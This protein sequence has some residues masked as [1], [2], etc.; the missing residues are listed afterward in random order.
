MRRSDLA[1]FLLVAATALALSPTPRAQDEPPLFDEKA[2]PQPSPT[3]APEA[4]PSPAPE[5]PKAA[6]EAAARP[7]VI[8]SPLSAR[9]D[10]ARWQSMTPR[11]RQVFVEGA[12]TALAT[13]TARLRTEVGGDSRAN[14]DKMV[15]LVRFIH[16]NEPRHTAD[17]YLREMGSLYL[18]P[19]GQ[20]LSIPECFARALARLNGR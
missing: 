7:A 10:Y 12:V 8:T 3:P 17:A 5:A 6:P 18:T 16:D 15:A 9:L 1:A 19:E 2:A 14:P 11:E 20:K 4:Q 13:L